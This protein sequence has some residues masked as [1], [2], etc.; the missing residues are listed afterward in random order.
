MSVLALNN[1]NNMENTLIGAVVV[2]IKKDIVVYK[3][4]KNDFVGINYKTNKE[5]AVFTKDPSLEKKV[6][7]K[8]IKALEG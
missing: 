3:S 4:V 2:E 8:I 6:I 5:V 7:E 1:Y